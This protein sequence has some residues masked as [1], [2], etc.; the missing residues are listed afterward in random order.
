MNLLL[1]WSRS[2]LAAAM[3]GGLLVS[4]VL[5]QVAVSAP[6]TVRLAPNGDL[7]TLDPLFNTAYI[8]RNHGYLVFDTLFSQD[9][10]GEPKPQMVDTFEYSDD[11][12]KWRFTLRDG[13]LFNDGTPV[14]SEDCIA[15]L[16]R[17][18]KKD[19]LGK[20]LFLH[21]AKFT[22]VNDKTFELTLEKPFGL[23]LAALSKPSGLPPF[24]MPKRLAETDP[25]VPVTEMVGSGPFIFKK[26]E[27]VPGNKVVYEKNPNYVPR[28]E[29]ADGL[30]GGKVAH[31]DRVEWIYIPDANTAAA[32]LQ[33]G[34]V[35]MIESVTPDFLP[36]LAGNPD[37]TLTPTAASQ[38]MIIPNHLHP[39]FNHPKVRQALLHLIDQKETVTAVGYTGDYATEY[40]PSLYTCSSPLAT[41]AGAEPYKKVDVERAKELLKEAGYNGEKVVILYP[42]DNVN[43][44]ANLVVAEALKRAGVNVDLQAMD[45]ASVAA[46][47]LRKDAPDQ[48]GWNIFLTHGGYFDAGTPVTNPWLSAPCGNGL[49]GWPCDEELDRLRAQWIAEGDPEQ[50]K[51]LAA[52]IQRRAYEVVPYVVW[53]EFKPVIASK[54]LKN[55][56]LL[57]TG[58]PVMWNLSK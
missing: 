19:T 16:E 11:G 41:D 14:T 18:A 25:S 34:E 53:G 52:E 48:G 7:K 42:T 50:S 13:L 17:W 55:I 3:V 5:P 39:P 40:C 28:K 23:V 35:D 33:N 12:L 9:S 26:K 24:I 8:T 2:R 4:S 51:A 1:N 43:S 20:L 32:A 47:R 58:V 30:A 37:V 15:S 56:E 36:L 46:R 22:A 27:W 54:G 38:G 44:P 21:G 49:P 6:V 31:V 29:P 45:W 10:K 57:K